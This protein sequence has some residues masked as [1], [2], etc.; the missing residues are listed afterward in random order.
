M[1]RRQLLNAI[2]HMP[3]VWSLVAMFLISIGVSPQWAFVTSLGVVDVL[4]EAVC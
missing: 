3:V 4:H 1:L 2:I